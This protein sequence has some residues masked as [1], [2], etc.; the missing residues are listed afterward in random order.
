MGFCLRLFNKRFQKSN[1]I[2]IIGV[3]VFFAILTIPSKISTPIFEVDSPV[4]FVKYLMPGVRYFARAGMVTESLLCVCCAAVIDQLYAWFKTSNLKRTFPC[5]LL[6]FC[7][8]DLSPLS[9]KESRSAYAEFGGIRSALGRGQSDP[10][11]YSFSPNLD[12]GMYLN[13]K[14]VNNRSDVGWNSD[15]EVQAALGDDNFAAYLAMRGVS[16]VLIPDQEGNSGSF[17][18][19]WGSNSS[20]NL[21]FPSRLYERVPTP[22]NEIQT[23]LYKVRSGI[24]TNFCSE[25][26]RYQLSWSG[27][28]QAFFDPGL[29]ALSWE[30]H[31]AST[32]SSWVLPGESPTVNVLS[33]P[34][35]NATFV[36]S[37]ELVAA[38]GPY[39]QPQIVQLTS[40]L[41]T[42]IYKVVARSEVIA[43]IRTSA[44]KTI[45]IRHFLPCTV[46]AFHEPGNPDTRAICYAISSLQVKQIAP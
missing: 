22:P 15:F 9:L 16:Y 32:S 20:I 44:N 24:D 12:A 25:C 28:R 45:S 35:V 36:V 41:E 21:R 43:E 5:L 37:I 23:I 1:F 39:A 27:V 18:K 13:V 6:V 38:Y 7:L 17:L 4:V 8:I 46:P 26:V 30:G 3:A 19:K 42:K 11:L 10:I 34:N 2:S 31:Q 40:D 33:D 29:G 14:S